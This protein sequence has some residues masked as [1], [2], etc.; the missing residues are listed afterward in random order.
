MHPVYLGFQRDWP[1]Y[2]KIPFTAYGKYWKKHELFEWQIQHNSEASRVAQLYNAG[3]IHH[4]EERM[5]EEKSGDRLMEMNSEQLYRVVVGIN[6][7][8]KKNTSSNT[9]FTKKKCKLSKIKDKQVGLIRSTLYRQPW[10]AE[11]FNKIR[12]HVL[13]NEVVKED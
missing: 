9:E 7:Y 4:D 10:V 12:D 3:Y 6:D 1:V 5:K 13:S 2:V 11:E 8:I